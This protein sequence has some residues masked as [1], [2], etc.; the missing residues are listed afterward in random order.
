MNKGVDGFL[1]NSNCLYIDASYYNYGDLFEVRY[2]FKFCAN[3]LVK[4][5]SCT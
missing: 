5:A 3:P 2:F 1:E 4:F